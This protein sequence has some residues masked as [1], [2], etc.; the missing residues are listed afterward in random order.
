[1]KTA[2]EW[3]QEFDILYNN[4]NSNTAPALDTYE[5]SVF[6]TMAQEQVV[7]T[8]YSG[9][10][11]GQDSFETT[12]LL[13]RSL[14]SLIREVEFT[15]TDS[16]AQSLLG[17]DIFDLSNLKDKVLYITYEQLINT[18]TEDCANGSILNVVPTTQDVYFKTKHNPFRGAN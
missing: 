17:G 11:L 4:I 15:D 18:N 5:K 14:D 6:L 16:E 13:R 9:G 7:K 12:E 1:M 10:A 2:Q 8:L 3:E